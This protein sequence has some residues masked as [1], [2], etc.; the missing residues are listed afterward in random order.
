MT[1]KN[2]A[3]VEKLLLPY[4][5]FDVINT[6]IG[7][8]IKLFFFEHKKQY[9]TVTAFTKLVIDTVRK[10]SPETASR[11]VHGTLYNTIRRKLVA[12]K[13]FHRHAERQK[14]QTDLT[15]LFD[16]VIN[17]T[18]EVTH[19]LLSSTVCEPP[20]PAE[21]A[22][23]DEATQPSTDVSVPMAP[24]QAVS[25]ASCPMAASTTPTM[26]SEL[27]SP[28]DSTVS[29]PSAERNVIET[30][31][32]L[33]VRRSNPPAGTPSR[34]DV[35]PPH[36]RKDCPKCFHNRKYAISERKRNADYRTR[37]VDAEAAVACAFSAQDQALASQHT[38]EQQLRTTEQQL[39]TTQDILDS[40]RKEAAKIRRQCTTLEKKSGM[41]VGNDRRAAKRKLQLPDIDP[42][43]PPRKPRLVTIA[44]SDLF[45]K[46]SLIA[47]QDAELTELRNR[48]K[49]LDD[50]VRQLEYDAE[51]CDRTCETCSDG[52]I[53]TKTPVGT[54]NLPTRKTI[55]KS[56]VSGTPLA[57]T[58]DLIK[59]TVKTMTGREVSDL[60][61]AGHISK[62]TKELQSIN[63][64]VVGQK[65]LESKD[66]TL[67]WDATTESADH[68]NELHVTFQDKTVMT[69]NIRTTA[70]SSADDYLEHTNHTFN[71]IASS[72]A[73][74]TDDFAHRLK[75]RLT[76]AIS[77]TMSDRVNTNKKLH[78]LL[79]EQIGRDLLQLHCNLHPL[80]A[81]ASQAREACK[82]YDATYETSS[83]VFGTNGRAANLLYGISKMR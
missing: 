69:L 7:H 64:I 23:R 75:T 26:V 50:R 78:R 68:F 61:T 80:D 16:T 2:D 60:P 77:N 1:S 9:D 18:P 67:A 48:V 42:V 19:P 17:L 37:V 63:N 79:Q 39:R 32:P 76:D 36:L 66:A 51:M 82:R 72:L 58:A 6:R 35:S 41:V 70:G 49:D 56:L 71:C 30:P 38:T 21:S 83:D 29:L 11:I 45:A 65:L 10:I 57:K 20:P 53:V 31:S 28:A 43:P 55:Y 15:G 22:V 44:S 59:Y 24:P 3:V 73:T 13:K 52:P 33:P 5:E 46:D 74:L 47:S 62:M 8:I 4:M 14:S 34:P 27:A 54:F 81:M 25:P 12:F 40:K